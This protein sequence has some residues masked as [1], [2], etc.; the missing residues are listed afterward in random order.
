M[1]RPL[2]KAPS[3]NLARKTGYF[4]PRPL[5]LTFSVTYR[6]NS[7]C[8]TCNV[9]KK[10]VDD[11]SLDEYK[12][13]FDNI[14][15]SLY[16][17]TFSGGEP[18]IRPDLIDIVAA[19]YDRCRPGIIT[20]PTNGLL[21]KRIVEGVARLSR[22]AP[23]TKI[24]INFSL[25]GIG[26]RHDELRKVPGNYEK[27]RQAYKELKAA[28][29]PNVTV[30]IHTVVSQFNVR[31]VPALRKHVREEFAP[32]SYIT[33]LAEER[34]ELDTIGLD[35]TPAANDYGTV[36]QDLL[37]DMDTTPGVGLA[38]IVQSFRRE[39]YQLA[40]QTLKEQ[41]QV[42]PCYAGL[43][44]AQIA[45]NGDVWTC[46]T[47]AESMGNLRATG[48]DFMKVWKSHRAD[49]LRRSIARGECHCP[50]ANAAYSSMLCDPPSIAR[51]GMRWLG[52]QLK[53]ASTP[54]PAPV[55]EVAP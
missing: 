10:R 17:A 4:R 36:V 54:R 1:L 31:E 40:H 53:P 19:C 50:L 29:H 55:G 3:Y 37:S 41:R 14:G 25:D 5:N 6:C 47:R 24:I 34:L 52:S 23:D 15:R 26:E 22:H 42:L 43:A 18:F 11:F 21:R 7:K 2:L 35:I 51:V 13:L 38:S 28:A 8:Q 9:W 32:D 33:E 39:Y 49:E 30:G 46:C 48:F 20:I 12:A 16:W 27:L 44:S 45:P